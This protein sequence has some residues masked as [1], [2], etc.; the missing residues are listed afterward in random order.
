MFH[1]CAG[2][3]ILSPLTLHP[4]RL[5]SLLGT[6]ACGM[7]GQACLLFISSEPLGQLCTRVDVLPLQS[8]VWTTSDQELE[9]ELCEIRI[10]VSPG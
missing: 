1:V 9:K 6:S 8:S 3:G 2:F 10:V 4:D 7:E 5:W